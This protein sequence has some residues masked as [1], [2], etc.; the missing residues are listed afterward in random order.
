MCPHHL[1]ALPW[2]A[3]ILRSC[4]CLQNETRRGNKTVLLLVFRMS[5]RWEWIV[6]HGSTPVISHSYLYVSRQ[7]ACCLFKEG[8]WPYH[9]R[10]LLREA[11]LSYL[12]ALGVRAH[13]YA[14]LTLSSCQ[15][16]SNYASRWSEAERGFL[17]DENWSMD[18]VIRLLFTPQG[19][20]L[21]MEGGITKNSHLFY[22]THH[23][24]Q[25]HDPIRQTDLFGE[26]LITRARALQQPASITS[27]SSMHHVRIFFC[28][29]SSCVIL[30]FSMYFFG[31]RAEMSAVRTALCLSV[32][33]LKWQAWCWT[34]AGKVRGG[35]ES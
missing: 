5:D 2:A 26:W 6:L 24:S 28:D 1:V 18:N 31:G 16:A 25:F 11:A 3:G 20:F 21:L 12:H 30:F 34:A 32:L 8:Q 22:P 9:G 7:A 15:D 27:N 19:C 23:F 35:L 29:I 17:C 33:W 4:A 10:D 13:W 14:T